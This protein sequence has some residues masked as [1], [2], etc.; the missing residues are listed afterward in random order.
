MAS[1]K[2]PRLGSPEEPEGGAA[3]AADE[4]A[5]ALEDDGLADGL[6]QPDLAALE[7]AEAAQYELEQIN[8]EASDRVLA[9]E[10]EFNK[11]RRPAYGAR[12]A[13]LSR[14][15][16]F[17][18]KVLMVHPIVRNVVTE[19]DLDVMDYLVDVDVED[20]AD[21]KSGFRVR[22]AFAPSN[23]YFAN[24]ELVKELRFGDDASLAVT[25]TDIQ[26]RPGM[27]PAPEEEDEEGS[28]RAGDKRGAPAGNQ[29]SLF[30]LWFA[31]GEGVQSHDDIADVLKDDIWPDPLRWYREAAEDMGG[32]FDGDQMGASLTTR[33]GGRG[34]GDEEGEEGFDGDASADAD[35][36]RRRAARRRAVAAGGDEYAQDDG[37]VGL[38]AGGPSDGGEGDDEGEEGEEGDDGDE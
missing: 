26:W 2:R 31:S 17:W 30:S 10:Q 9:V 29:Y 33:G 7:A 12:G 38:P 21:I 28:P 25:G 16:G 13:A 27:E 15:P 34:G 5:A 23:P 24:T 32:L 36:A 20:F 37:L 1:P 19:A 8:D 4:G 18:K 6:D 11:R 3:A 35:A 22:F 14:I